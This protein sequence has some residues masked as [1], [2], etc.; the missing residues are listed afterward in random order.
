M[1]F[2]AKRLFGWIAV[3][4]VLGLLAF[5]KLPFPKESGAA[6]VG[7]VTDNRLNVNGFVVERHTIMDRIRTTGTIRAGEQIE[8][9]NEV[10]GL[11]TGIHFEEG[12]PVRQGQLLLKIND[13]EL[14]AQHRRAEYRLRLAEGREQR[15]KALLDKGGISLEEYEATL[16]ELNVLRAEVDLI[17]AQ[18]VRTEVRAP[19]DGVIGLRNISVGSFLSAGTHIASLQSVNPVKIDFSI[20][21][22]FNNRVNTGDRIVFT[23]EGISG[24]FTGQ[25]YAFEPRIDAGT[26][27]LLVRATS[28]NP[29]RAL[30]PGAF[31]SIEL[32]FDEIRDA[33]SVPAEAVVPEL[34]GARLFVYEGGRVAT[35][36]VEVGIREADRVQIVSGISPQ[37]TVITTGVQQLRAGMPVRIN[38]PVTGE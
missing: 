2:S 16:N 20:P 15:Q 27:S 4:I 34:G 31:A 9:R 13:S 8:V 35:R 38:V 17:E 12:R 3:A 6:A 7:P 21:E 26:R 22:R 14:Q 10:A 36:V 1:R 37:D 29:A 24:S 32:V 25:V 18:I 23:V 28:P 19:F 33:M 11:V 30:V 5:P